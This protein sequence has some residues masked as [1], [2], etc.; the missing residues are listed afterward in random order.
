[1]SERERERERERE[2]ERL[3]E[4]ERARAQGAHKGEKLSFFEWCTYEGS[5]VSCLGLGKAP[6]RV[7]QSES[8]EDPSENRD[9]V[10]P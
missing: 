4:R 8:A 2:I 9:E 10:G 3:R 6:E 5:A 1:M 7:V